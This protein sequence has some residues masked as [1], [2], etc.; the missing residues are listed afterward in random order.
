MPFMRGLGH[1]MTASPPNTITLGMRKGPMS[2]EG[3][4]TSSLQQSPLRCQGRCPQGASGL[5]LLSQVG[6]AMRT[7]SAYTTV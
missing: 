2:L 7:G 1:L 6:Q 3:T 4:H 5:E